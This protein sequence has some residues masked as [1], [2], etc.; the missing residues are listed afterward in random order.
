M[1][2]RTRWVVLGGGFVAYMFDAMEII[3]LSL[4][5]PAIRQ[6]MHLT[7]A[8]GGLLATATL[9]GIGLS[10]VL[11]G[12]LADNFGRKKALIASLL[13]FGLFTS[14]LSVVPNYEVFL[15]FRFVAG[16]GLGG[17]WSVVSAYVV[18]TWPADKRGRAAAFVL[19][20]FPIGGAVAAVT[21]GLFL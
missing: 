5:L 7:A 15:L 20:S 16:F 1:A 14:L 18:E 11:A 13:T 2:A 4:A 10:S 21:S 3:L 9:L 17:V 19:S 12:Y 6:N 8:Q